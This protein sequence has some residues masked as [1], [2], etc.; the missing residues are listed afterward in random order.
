MSTEKFAAPK[1]YYVYTYAYPDGTIFYI[2]KGT[3]GRIDQH[4]QEATR[5]ECTCK[6]CQV[7]R[8]IWASGKPV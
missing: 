6:R 4:E 1:T 5:S 2:G 7:I 3:D 8:Q